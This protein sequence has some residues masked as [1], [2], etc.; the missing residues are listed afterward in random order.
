MHH[1]LLSADNSD[2]IIIGAS[3]TDHLISNLNAC[4]YIIHIIII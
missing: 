2:S 3:T 1:S 4:K